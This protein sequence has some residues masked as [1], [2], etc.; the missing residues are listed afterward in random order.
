MTNNPRKEVGVFVFN[1]LGR[2][3]LVTALENSL[4]RING[5]SITVQTYSWKSRGQNPVN[6]LLFDEPDTV[7]VLNMQSCKGLEFDAVF[8]VDL[9]NAQLGLNGPGRFKMMMF[10]AVSRARDFV[11]LID[12]GRQAR[13]GQYFQHLPGP[14]Y[15]DH[16]QT[17]DR[18]LMGASSRNGVS[19]KGAPENGTSMQ[20]PGKDN[21]SSS[22]EDTLAA[23]S[24]KLGLKCEDK[25]SK[26][27]ALWVKGG[28]ELEK[29]LQPLGFTYAA[30]R[31]AWWRR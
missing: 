22:W 23:L 11:N 31:S 9:H 2:Q 20:E 17:G 10:V 27:G 4:S 29:L 19:G 3:N 14:Q 25:R 28:M 7:T 24:R 16:E 12:S 6:S 30:S 18:G 5:R 13:Q 21:L 26:D 15:L 1:E 8:I